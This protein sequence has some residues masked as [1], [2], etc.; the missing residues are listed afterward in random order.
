[1]DDIETQQPVD[2]GHSTMELRD[3]HRWDSIVAGRR[4]DHTAQEAPDNA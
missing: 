1:M 3:E 2:P 4:T